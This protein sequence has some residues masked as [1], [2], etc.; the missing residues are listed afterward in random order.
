MQGKRV[1]SVVR[2]DCKKNANKKNKIAKTS[3]RMSKQDKKDNPN[4][5]KENAIPLLFFSLFPVLCI[6]SS[7]YQYACVGVWVL[8][9]HL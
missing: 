6:E 8:H 1:V 2:F 9:T 4:E 3:T 5:K 7:K